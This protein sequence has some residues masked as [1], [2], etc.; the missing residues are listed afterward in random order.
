MIAFHLFW[1]PVYRYGLFYGI[2]FLSG[3]LFLEWIGRK[4]LLTSFPRLHDLFTVHLDAFVLWVIWWI[5]LG[6]RLGHVFLYD[7]WYYSMHLWEILQVRQWGMSFIGWVGGVVLVLLG[8][9]H[10]YKLSA[11]D[12]LLLGDIVLCIVPLGILLWRIGNFLNK[13]L[14][15]LPIESSSSWFDFLVRWW[16]AVDYGIDAT[17]TMRINTNIVQ[18]LGEWLIPLLIGQWLFF[19]QI[20]R[21][22]FRP[23]LISWWFFIVYACVRFFAEYL[24]ELPAHE[25]Y[26]SLSISQWLMFVFFA[27]WVMLLVQA[28]SLARD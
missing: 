23:W 17:P 5:M 7:R 25:M 27:G 13:E 24:K 12:F 9:R 11:R 22:H 8:M 6:G 16:L 15:G 4:K 2:T 1:R 14:Y 20:V 10:Y 26:A 19:K 18:S 3:Y 28:Y 21:R